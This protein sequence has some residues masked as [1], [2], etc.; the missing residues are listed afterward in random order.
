[1]AGFTHSVFSR[2]ILVS[3]ILLTLGGVFYVGSILLEPVPVPPPPPAKAAVR[4]DVRSDITKNPLFPTLQPLG[5]TEVLPGTLGRLNPFAPVP[6]ASTSTP[7]ATVT[8]TAPVPVPETPTTT[9]TPT[10]T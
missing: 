5:P 7:A 1:M 2:I 8:S 4:F 9:A 6:P 10:S 3:V